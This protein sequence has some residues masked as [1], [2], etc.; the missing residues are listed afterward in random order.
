MFNEK[1]AIMTGWLNNTM[2]SGISW[3]RSPHTSNFTVP[4]PG[5]IFV[6]DGNGTF[7][8]AAELQNI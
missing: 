3:L 4:L 1:L 2:L 7:Y 8:L 5:G 6:V